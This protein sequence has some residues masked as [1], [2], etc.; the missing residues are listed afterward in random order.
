MKEILNTSEIGFDEE[1]TTVVCCGQQQKEQAFKSDARGMWWHPLIVR[2][3]LSIYHT[4][5]A[6][7]KQI[8]D[9]KIGFLKLPHK[10]TEKVH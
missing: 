9:Q 4:S 3:C 1:S 6:A 10:Y 2:W 8:T 5:P 7:Y